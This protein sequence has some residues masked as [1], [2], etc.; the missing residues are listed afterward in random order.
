MQ[1]NVLFILFGVCLL[2]LLLLFGLSTLFASR[3]VRPVQEAFER[4]KNFVADASHE[5]KTPLAII[6]ANLSV[7]E[8]NGAESVDSQSNG[9]PLCAFRL[10]V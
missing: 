10:P 3:T 9:F 2:S 1:R 4:Q 6:N 8:E 5:L 7:L